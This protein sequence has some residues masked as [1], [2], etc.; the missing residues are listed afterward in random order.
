MGWCDEQ[1]WPPPIVDPACERELLAACIVNPSASPLAAEKLSADD[2]GVPLHGR[3]FQAVT[4]VLADGKKPDEFMLDNKLRGEPAY[5]S[6]GG[7]HF[8]IEITGSG[9][10][11]AR[12]SAIDGLA[13]SVKTNALRRRICQTLNSAQKRS[14]DPLQTVGEQITD[15]R[16]S[17][18][19]LEDE[20]ET[21]QRG[22]IH[23]AERG[24]SARFSRG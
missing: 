17:V 16:E 9:F 19:R 4:D 18:T 11:L 1:R 22:M 12:V 10:S 24:N 20:S 5:D 7:L 8:L 21:S 23:V 3:I 2:F 13:E 6:A 15:L 14:E